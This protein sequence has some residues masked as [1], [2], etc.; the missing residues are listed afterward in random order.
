MPTRIARHGLQPRRTPRQRRSAQTV[1]AIVEAAARLLESRGLAAFNTNA[2][3]ERAGISVGS[4]YQYFPG[5]DALIAALGRR[6]RQR[7]AAD[8]AAAARAAAGQPLDRALGT[9]A[10]AAI[11]HRLARP[12]LARILDFAE[13]RLGRDAGDDPAT[14]AVAGDVA[15]VLAAHRRRMPR[16]RLDATVADL[17]ALTRALIDAAARRGT[18]RPAA[19]ERRIVRAALGYLGG[20][21]NVAP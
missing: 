18:P 4:L 10:R 21:A 19:P 12:E 3:A 11:R 5:K 8:I 17:M 15:A 20:R 9:L 13:P 1:D 7:L 14:R 6:E 2:V 16:Q